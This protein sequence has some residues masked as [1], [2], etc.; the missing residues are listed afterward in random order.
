MKNI[1]ITLKSRVYKNKKNII[2][3][4]IDG[5]VVMLSIDKGEYYNLDSVGSVIWESLG[6]AEYVETLIKRLI[7]IYDGEESVMTEQTIKILSVL[8]EKGIIRVEN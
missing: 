5:E 1:E 6:E 4:E 3:N 7:D 8:R 2:T